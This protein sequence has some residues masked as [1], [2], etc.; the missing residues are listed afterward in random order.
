MI[1]FCYIS[2]NLKIRVGEMYQQLKVDIALESPVWLPVPL[3]GD[4]KVLIPSF[5]L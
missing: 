1:L 3:Y 5:G 4:S 2:E